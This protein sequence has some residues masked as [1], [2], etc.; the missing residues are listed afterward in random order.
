M[1]YRTFGRFYVA[2]FRQKSLDEPFSFKAGK[3]EEEKGLRR[4]LSLF[5]LLCIGVGSTVG[6]GVFVL[7]GIIARLFSGPGV[8]ISWL[9][10]GFAC[11]CSAMSFAELSVRVSSS[12]S[13]YAYVYVTLGEAPAFIA[14]WCLTLE[15]GV[16]GAAVARA[17]GVK[18]HNYLLDIGAYVCDGSGPFSCS[19]SGEDEMGMN[20]Y[21]GGLQLLTVIIFLCGGII[22]Q[23][24]INIFTILKMLL[25]V[26]MI[27]AGLSRFNPSHV[28]VIVPYGTQG[29][30]RGATSCFFGFVGYDEVCCMASEA[31]N[32]NRDLPLAVL[33]TIS[34][35]TVFY[36]LASRLIW[37]VWWTTNKST[38]TEAL[39]LPSRTIIWCGRAKSQL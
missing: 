23:K 34:I 30:L 39:Q 35:V 32:P 20:F 4:T 18:L 29:L 28:Q 9:I 14:A 6:G 22:G 1:A 10:A 31:K 12:G 21:A 33:G 37:W 38:S 8:V 25:I 16:G 36:C 27:I 5:D 17:W 11:L 15:C 19:S 7:T 3:G 24:T 13:S 2:A 26:F